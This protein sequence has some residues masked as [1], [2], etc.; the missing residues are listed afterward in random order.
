M[1]IRSMFAGAAVA[2]L[3]CVQTPIAGSAAAQGMGMAEEMGSGMAMMHGSGSHF[4]MLLRS[5]NLSPGQQSQ[6][7]QIL[8]SNAQPMHAIRQ[9]MQVIHEQLANKLFATGRVSA[10]DLKPQ[11]AQLAQLQQQMDENMLD[12]ALSIRSVLTPQQLAKLAQV[13]AQLLNLHK[14]VQSLMG[15]EADSPEQVPN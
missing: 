14:Q 15:P 4:L 5:A 6:V 12:T 8:H 9:Q 11:I 3:I 1:N 13:H 10:A 7:R 2:A